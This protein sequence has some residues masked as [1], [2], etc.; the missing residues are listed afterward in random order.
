MKKLSTENAPAA[1]GPYSQGYKA[2]GFIYT[3][4][5]IPIDMKTGELVDD[6]KMAT[7]VVLDN[8]RAILKSGGADLDSVIKTT[9]FLRDMNDFVQMNEV[10]AEIFGEYAPARSTVQVAMLPKGAIIEIEAIA[11]E[12]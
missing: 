6:I 3:S 1:I 8:I 9:V 5:Q 2:N 12:K 11:L 4:G 10:Y 7:R